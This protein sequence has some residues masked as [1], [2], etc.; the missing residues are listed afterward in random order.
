[1]PALGML[2]LTVR[3]RGPVRVQGEHAV[4]AEAVAVAVAMAVAAEN[5]CDGNLDDRPS[6]GCTRRAELVHSAAP[7]E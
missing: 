4:V 7:A 6:G 3:P 1:M 2:L 5:W